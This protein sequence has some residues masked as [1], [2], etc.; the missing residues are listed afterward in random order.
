[1]QRFIQHAT[2]IFQLLRPIGGLGNTSQLKRLATH[3]STIPT[4]DYRLD[5]DTPHVTGIEYNTM[6]QQAAMTASYV[7]MFTI[8]AVVL[9]A[10]VTTLFLFFR[11]LQAIEEEQWGDNAH[12]VS[13]IFSIFLKKS[14]KE[15]AS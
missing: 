9:V 14:K 13:G 8:C 12:T 10:M 7:A 2:S 15:T 6:T 4:A 5:V 3:L 11:R 1:M